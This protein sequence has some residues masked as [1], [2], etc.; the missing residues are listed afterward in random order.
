MSEASPRGTVVVLGIFAADLAFRA[1]RLPRI[2]ET[3][4]ANGFELGPGG[5]GSNQAVAAA[6]CGADVKMISRL[7]ADAFGEIAR[8]LWGGEGIDLRF[9]AT[10]DAAPTGA[11]FIY[12]DEASGHNAIIV[13]AGAA[14]KL[15]AADLGAARE[16]IAAADIFM[17]QL[18][19]PI[20]A[21]LAGLRIA[22][23]SGVRT[24][25]N[26]APAADLPDEVW[27]L[28]DYATPNE[29]EAG[30]ITGIEV[31]DLESARK[32]ASALVER[33]VGCAVL[34]LGAAG[35]LVHSAETSL[36]IPAVDAGPVVDTTGAGD[37]FNGGFA[38]ALARGEAPERAARFA[39]AVAG[40]SVTRKGAAR[41][42]PSLEEATRLLARTG[43]AG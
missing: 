5:K 25:L 20:E 2:G 38:A 13:E 26:P 30:A 19:Q 16:V 31:S 3:L 28:C 6:R 11:A 4:L 8:A 41:S 39:C 18:E 34:T 17:T 40:L 43:A 42:M 32:A 22:K 10:D 35:V 7:G 15:S 24:I 33:G 37:A 9:V 14:K 23:G 27:P 29:S 1:P 12:V 36:H 21:A